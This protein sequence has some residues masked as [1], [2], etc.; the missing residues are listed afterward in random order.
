MAGQAKR[1][2]FRLPLKE[3]PSAINSQRAPHGIAARAPVAPASGRDDATQAAAGPS[4][5]ER[6]V[7]RVIYTKRNPQKKARRG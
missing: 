1:L 5:S 2:G 3:L 4:R 7:F 6:T